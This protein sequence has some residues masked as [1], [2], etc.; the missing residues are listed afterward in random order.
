MPERPS[1]RTERPF[2][3]LRRALA[4][5]ILLLAS[6][7]ALLYL[8]QS[9]QAVYWLNQVQANR[10]KLLELQAQRDQLQLQV[11]QAFSLERIE[12]FARQ[13]LGMIHPPLKL[14]LLPQVG[15]APPASPPPQ[16]K[17]P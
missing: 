13:R 1:A 8:W 11:A 2:L 14:L 9:W 7:L 3:T 4:L 5:I 12:A 10:E 17:K 6:T 15:S 16:A